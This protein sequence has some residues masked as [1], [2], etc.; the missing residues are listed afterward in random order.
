MHLNH[1]SNKIN[2][3]KFWWFCSKNPLNVLK[4][5]KKNAHTDRGF[6]SYFF[7]APFLSVSGAR[8]DSF[9]QYINVGF[10]I[11]NK[12]CIH[13]YNQASNTILLIKKKCKNLVFNGTWQLPCLWFTTKVSPS[14]NLTG[15]SEKFECFFKEGTLWF[16]LER[17][18]HWVKNT[19][20]FQKM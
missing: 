7:K 10:E 8:I 18:V 12:T 2:Y 16:S 1:L 11:L 6:Q 15:N 13:F 14:T 17:T 3:G 20:K 9:C 4:A 5:Y 19:K